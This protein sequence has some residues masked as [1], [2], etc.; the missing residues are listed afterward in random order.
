MAN[1]CSICCYIFLFTDSIRYVE[2]KMK[3]REQF[4][5]PGREVQP[6]K[7]SDIDWNKCFICQEGSA[8]NL[9][10]P[11]NSKS[12][13][14]QESYASL[15]ERIQKFKCFRELPAQIN[16]ESLEAGAELGQSLLND[17]AKHHRKCYE[18]FSNVKLEH[19]EKRDIK[20]QIGASQS[21]GPTTRS[22]GNQI[23]K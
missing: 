3:R 1:I 4:S 2:L 5:S 11:L 9:R 19:M 12:G 17:G 15:A 10:C 23:L 18:M 7:A 14:A 21:D 20:N 8:E 13:I 6:K 22:T 16:L